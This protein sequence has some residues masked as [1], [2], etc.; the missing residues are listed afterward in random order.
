MGGIRFSDLSDPEEES[1][2][3]LEEGIP[4]TYQ[5]TDNLGNTGEDDVIGSRHHQLCVTDTSESSA[6]TSNPRD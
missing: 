5:G 6:E 1:S 4:E 2:L 3:G